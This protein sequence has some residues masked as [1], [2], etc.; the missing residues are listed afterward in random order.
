MPLR[1]VL[2]RVLAS[3][4]FHDA[5]ITRTSMMPSDPDLAKKS[6]SKVETAAV[7]RGILEDERMEHP[8]QRP[9]ED[10]LQ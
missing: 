7:L 1:T 9:R 6:I 2:N 3:K 4:M 8:T 10:S 5:N